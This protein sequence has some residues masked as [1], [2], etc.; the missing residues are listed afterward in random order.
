MTTQILGHHL[1][2]VRLHCRDCCHP[3]PQVVTPC[4]HCG[5]PI[6]RLRLNA[7]SWWVAVAGVAV[8]LLGVFG[9]GPAGALVGR[10]AVR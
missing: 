7:L 3:T 6:P 10:V 5:A 4:V 2:L 9:A 8:V 1:R